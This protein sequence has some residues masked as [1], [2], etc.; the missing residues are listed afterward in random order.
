[1]R[2]ATFNEVIDAIAIERTFQDAKWGSIE[3]NPHDKGTWFILT[4]AEL[5]EV[6]EALIKGGTG[7]NSFAQELV[8]VAA[9]CVATLEQHGLGHKEGRDL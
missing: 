2:K 1:M 8:Q 3:S 6:K 5:S 7:R 9:L 4:E